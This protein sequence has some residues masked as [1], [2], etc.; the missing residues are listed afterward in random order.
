M[1]KTIMSLLLFAVCAIASATVTQK[2]YLKNGTVLNGFIKQQDMKGNITVKTESAVICLSSFD[3][4]TEDL[5]V[6]ESALTSEW[7]KWAEEND[8]LTGY[9]ADKTLTLSNVQAGVGMDSIA[10]DPEA[11]NFEERL[12]ENGTQFRNVKILERGTN[13]RFLELAPNS[14]TIKWSDIDRIEGTRRPK[15]MLTGIMRTYTLKDGTTVKGEYAGETYETISVF[16][17]DGTVE[18]MPAG[19]IKSLQL[20][21]INP[22]QDILQQSKLLDVITLKNGKKRTGVVTEQFNG[23]KTS[24]ENYITLKESNGTTVNIRT[25]DAASLGKTENPAYQPVTDVILRTGEVMINRKK[26]A[27]TEAAEKDGTLTLKEMP[28]DAIRIK[29]NG[30]TATFFVEYNGNAGGEPFMVVKLSKTTTKKATSYGF[31]Y[32]DLALSSYNAAK[33]ERSVN[34]TVKK[35]FILPGNSTYALYFKNTNSVVPVIAE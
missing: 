33:E 23:G 15:N 12:K 13:V 9:G 26:A 35:T 19:D 30:Q 8:A 18:T 4:E 34:G 24:A 1:K 20:A 25:V 32:K 27:A 28:A 14:Y 7:K 17:N 5:T 10:R 6:R 11:M 3:V 21:A 2:F 22:N 29:G 16:K 31:S